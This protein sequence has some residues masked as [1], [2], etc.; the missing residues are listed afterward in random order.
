MSTRA[1]ITALAAVGIAL[2]VLVAVVV[3]VVV[4]GKSTGRHTPT[5][6]TVAPPGTTSSTSTTAATTTTTFAGGPVPAGFQPQSVTFV[7]AR[8]AMVL[9]AAPCAE[10]PCPA[11]V[12]RTTDAGS[13]WHTLE[14][15]GAPLVAA[16]S[17]SAGVSELRFA[18]AENG[19]AFGSELWS[20]HDGGRSW[21]RVTI[22]GAGAGATVID[23]EA[24]SGLADALV[25]TPAGSSGQG[26]IALYQSPVGSDSWAPVA[27]V[28]A[29]DAGNGSI[30]LHGLSGWVLISSAGSGGSGREWTTVNGRTFAPAPPPS[31]PPPARVPAVLAASSTSSL[32]A[33]CAG[34]VAAGQEQKTVLA[35]SDGGMT[36]SAVAARPPLDGTIDALATPDP[37]TIV[38]GAS[39]GASWIYASFDG[40]RSWETVYSDDSSG[41]IPFSDLGFTT[42]S[43]GVVIEGI[44]AISIKNPSNPA[45]PPARLLM[46]T[47]GGHHWAAVSF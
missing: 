6:T 36:W 26:T 28:R 15:P 14:P 16:R 21:E 11:V 25:Q 29:A 32:A 4:T 30:V 19:W 23:L 45:F 7:S 39:S 40:G 34:G 1:R 17:A 27:G 38:L 43:Q 8:E 2:A 20:T 42:T 24:A 41:G 22:N 12:A 33:A 44:A 31:C 46:T 13:T 37:S 3:A 47:D 5:S 10:A 18:D 9:G 35:S